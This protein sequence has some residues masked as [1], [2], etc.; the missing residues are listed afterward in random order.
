MERQLRAELDT[1]HARIA[2]LEDTLRAIHS[3]EVDAI[4]VDSPHGCRVFTL[5]GPDEPYRILAERMN[6]G[7]ATLTMEGTVLFC[8][9]RLAEMLDIPAEKIVSS[10][11][12]ALLPEGERERFMRLLDTAAERDLRV[13]AH[14]VRKNGSTVPVQLSLSH[15][16]TED[17]SPGICVVASDLTAQKYIQ[18]QVHRLNAELEKRVDVRTA[19][20]QEANKELEAFSYAV[21]HDLR[22]PLRHLHGFSE[23]L[24]HDPDST[25]S[26]DARHCI[27]AITKATVRMETLVGHLLSL[28]RL[29]RQ[30]L[31]RRSVD[32]EQLVR[33]VL[34]ELVPDYSERQLEWR[35]GSL[36]RAICDPALVK[37][38][39]T[40]LL[41]NALKFTRPRSPAIIEV[42]EEIQNGELVVFVRDNGVG[43]DMNYADRLFGVFQRLHHDNDFEG[44]GVGLATV[45]RI[46]QKH[47]GKIWAEA[48]VNAGATFYFTLGAVLPI[49][50]PELALQAAI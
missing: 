9:R 44:T 46:V 36:A 6:E 3:G 48:R 27:E 42:G 13:E 37:V 15:I 10:A 20:L 22:A 45:R 8:N 1:A 28:S 40:N 43:F 14:L 26:P 31:S 38:L 25:L 29:G 12:T 30:S 39:L 18:E 24:H 47:G 2:E 5:Q 21:A 50:Q 33:E 41:S 7:A 19:E 35:I 16:P 4:V 49:D 23:M 32:L 17:P 34:D 11:F